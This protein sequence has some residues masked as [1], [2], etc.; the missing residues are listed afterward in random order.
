M[1]ADFFE[2]LDLVELDECGAR[3]PLLEREAPEPKFEDFD[4]D[5]VDFELWNELGPFPL[6]PPSL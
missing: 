5:E 4:E 1:G 2:W 3:V 6:A